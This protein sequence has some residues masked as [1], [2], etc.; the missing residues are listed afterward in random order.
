MTGSKFMAKFEINKQKFGLADPLA[1]MP[2]RMSDVDESLSK[3]NKYHHARD[4]Q[5]RLTE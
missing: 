2:L 3:D 5:A 1:G 4:G